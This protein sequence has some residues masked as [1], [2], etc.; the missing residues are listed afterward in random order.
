[1]ELNSN[2]IELFLRQIWA[3]RHISDEIL[4]SP[5]FSP[6]C[7]LIIMAPTA[8]AL[9]SPDDADITVLSEKCAVSVPRYSSMTVMV[10]RLA[11]LL[12]V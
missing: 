4:H 5:C 12:A 10:Y 9:L 6:P 3:A 11:Q 7:D 8:M 1:M 2:Q